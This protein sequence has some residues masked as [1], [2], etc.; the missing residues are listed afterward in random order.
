[1]LAVV[2]SAVLLGCDSDKQVVIPES[3]NATPV[4]AANQIVYPNNRSSYATT[5][6]NVGC[7]SK[8][9]AQKQENIFNSD[10][11][12]HWFEWSGTVVLPESNSTSLNVDG[13][14]TQDLRVDF[15]K[16]GAGYDLFEDQ[17]I[18][19]RFLMRRAGGC[20][21]PFSGDYALIVK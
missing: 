2:V 3:L 6:K 7:G 15:A 9:S 11:K 1:M 5:D 17:R 19:V 21:L 8:Y 20:F 13:I 16:N 4:A 10:Y 14:G 18:T 12:N